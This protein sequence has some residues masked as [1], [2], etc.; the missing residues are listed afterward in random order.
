LDTGDALREKDK[1]MNTRTC[2]ICETAG[3]SKPENH[4]CDDC[5][6][7][8][9]GIRYTERV[10]GK[11]ISDHLWV[12]M[13]WVCRIHHIKRD[14][15]EDV[16]QDLIIEA[17]HARNRYIPGESSLTTYVK[18]HIGYKAAD[19]VRKKYNAPK[20]AHR[21]E[22]LGIAAAD[23][24]YRYSVDRNKPFKPLTI[25]TNGVLQELAADGHE[26]DM[27]EKMDIDVIRT[28]L[29]PKQQQ[30]SELLEDGKTHQQIADIMGIKRPTASKYVKELRRK[31]NALEKFRKTR[32]FLATQRRLL[33][34]KPHIEGRV[35][36]A[37]TQEQYQLAG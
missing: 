5:I 36:P 7:P 18:T 23:E 17:L 26:H 19:I 29:T 25:V 31:F 13:N 6:E 21:Q 15:K 10:F 1:T 20:Q 12:K 3:P 28:T 27:P 22:L 35:P 24:Q 34:S 16:L 32:H 14:D 11:K 8:V 4:L 9:K 37:P 33:S 30:V 2:L